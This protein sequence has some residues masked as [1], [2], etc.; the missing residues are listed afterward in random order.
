MK[1]NKHKQNGTKTPHAAAVG[2]GEETKKKKQKKVGVAKQSDTKRLGLRG[3]GW[4]G[5]HDGLRL[6]FRRSA[7]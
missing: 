7:M 2:R 1:Q 6:L 4:V 3:W 5:G